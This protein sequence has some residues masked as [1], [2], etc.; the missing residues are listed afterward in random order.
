MAGHELKR[1]CYLAGPMEPNNAPAFARVPTNVRLTSSMISLVGQRQCLR[2]VS[3]HSRRIHTSPSRSSHPHPA[4]FAGGVFTGVLAAFLYKRNTQSQK[5][6]ELSPSHFTSTTL[7]SSVDSGKE[8]KLLQ[9]NLPSESFPKTSPIAIW[10]VYVKDSDIMVERPYTP[11]E[12]LNSSGDMLFWVK[13]YTH[14]EVGRWLHSKAVGEKVEIRGPEQTWSWQEG[15][16]DNVIM[17]SA[18]TI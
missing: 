18:Q 12:S 8:S 11:L 14:G 2:H 9:L 1:T 10:A 16:W 6:K 7:T 17:V 15:A 4:W 3:S 13:K 5:L